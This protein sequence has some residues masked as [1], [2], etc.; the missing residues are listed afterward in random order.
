MLILARASCKQLALI[1]AR[2]IRVAGGVYVKRG[3]MWR[4]T[5]NGGGA[6]GRSSEPAISVISAQAAWRHRNARSDGTYIFDKLYESGN[7]MPM[8]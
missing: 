8:M 3:D 6:Y 7:G 5:W 2:I 1:S 4:Q